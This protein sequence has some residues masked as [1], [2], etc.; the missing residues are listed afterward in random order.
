MK[1]FLKKRKNFK[2]MGLKFK[3]VCFKL[4]DVVQITTPK[5]VKPH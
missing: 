4:V 1:N 2:S 5:K 3:N